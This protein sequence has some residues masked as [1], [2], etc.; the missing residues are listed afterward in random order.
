MRYTKLHAEKRAAYEAAKPKRFGS[1]HERMK[2]LS[3]LA[4]EAYGNHHEILLAHPKLEEMRQ[5]I[6]DLENE[7]S[8]N[9]CDHLSRAAGKRKAFIVTAGK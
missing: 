7:V 5:V 3:H 2:Y 4:S 8:L 1:V 6:F 9:D